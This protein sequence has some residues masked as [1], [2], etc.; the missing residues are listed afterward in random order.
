MAVQTW[1]CD[2]IDQ[3]L[4]EDDGITMPLPSFESDPHLL[5]S[6]VICFFYCKHPLDCAFVRLISF[7]LG[8]QTLYGVCDQNAV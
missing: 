3:S 8:S 4:L 6:K 1:D 2:L 7:I 5:I